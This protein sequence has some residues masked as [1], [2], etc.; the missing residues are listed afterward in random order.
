M[1]GGVAIEEI[2][3]EQLMFPFIV[4]AAFIALTAFITHRLYLPD[5][6]NTKANEGERLEQAFGRFAI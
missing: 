3:V 2:H 5:V 4:L 1:F 6:M